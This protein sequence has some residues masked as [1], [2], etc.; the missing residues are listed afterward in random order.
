MQKNYRYVNLDLL[1]GLASLGV[2]FGHASWLLGTNNSHYSSVSFANYS[3]AFFLSL[4]GFVIGYNYKPFKFC[5][6]NFIF[7]RFSRI[8]PTLIACLFLTLIIDLIRFQIPFLDNQFKEN[9]NFFNLLTSLLL[10]DHYFLFEWIGFKSCLISPFGE[11]GSN[12]VLWTLSL[13]WSIYMLYAFL[14]GSKKRWNIS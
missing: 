4:S 13:E 12:R 10:L 3:V 6:K 8:Y 14:F 5:S 11:F 9:F 7:R 1:R 2:L